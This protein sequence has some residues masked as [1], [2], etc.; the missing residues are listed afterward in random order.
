MRHK[1]RNQR[2]DET[3]VSIRRRLIVSLI[4]QTAARHWALSTTAHTT[5]RGN[6][7]LCAC[8]CVCRHAPA[9]GQRVRRAAVGHDEGGQRVGEPA[10]Q[11]HPERGLRALRVHCG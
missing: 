4:A 6:V 3:E 11:H 2:D 1:G 8:V 10:A 9:T 5:H 7:L